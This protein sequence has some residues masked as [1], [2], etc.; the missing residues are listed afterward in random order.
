MQGDVLSRIEPLRLQP[1]FQARVWGGDRLDPDSPDP[2]GEAWVV[3]EGNQVVD[4]AWAGKTLLEVTGELGAELLGTTAV[5]QTSHGFPLLIK[6]LHSREWLSVQVHPNDEQAARLEGL[7]TVGKTEAWHV[8]E[9]DPGAQVIFGLNG[10]HSTAQLRRMA[11]EGT[12]EDVLRYVPVERGDTLFTPAGCVHAI[13]PG[14][15]IYEVQQTSDITYRLFDWNRP[16]TAGRALHLDKGLQVIGACEREAPESGQTPGTADAGLLADCTYFSLERVRGDDS[17]VTMDT[18][19]RSFHT[20]TVLEGDVSVQIGSSRLQIGPLET[21]LIP[22][23]LGSYE[24]HA[25]QPF[26]VLLSRVP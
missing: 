1:I 3:Y 10:D 14:L 4:G 16:E 24:L 25:L 23:A 18:G 9:A 21:I 13:G 15:L 19:G 11:R 26:E 22:A 12:F 6:L 17:P 7:N 2:I 5:A 20:L 8:L